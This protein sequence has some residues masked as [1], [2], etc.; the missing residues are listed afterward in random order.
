MGICL[1]YYA[2]TNKRIFV[3]K[4]IKANNETSEE[5]SEKRTINVVISNPRY[6]IERAALV[7][8]FYGLAHQITISMDQYLRLFMYWISHIYTLIHHSR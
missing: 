6:S 5:A 2:K 3:E 4:T 7:R 1:G 8:S